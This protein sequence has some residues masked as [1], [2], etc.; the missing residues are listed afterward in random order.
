M[1]DQFGHVHVD[2]PFGGKFSILFNY[3]SKTPY[4]PINTTI[5]SLYLGY[6]PDWTVKVLSGGQ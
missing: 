6:L 3:Y 2:R 4:F 1:A 5:M